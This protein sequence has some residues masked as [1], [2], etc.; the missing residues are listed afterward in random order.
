MKNICMVCGNTPKDEHGIKHE[1]WCRYW[2]P[3]W[4]RRGSMRVDQHVQAS[5]R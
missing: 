3:E 2:Q 5:K 1:T 4:I